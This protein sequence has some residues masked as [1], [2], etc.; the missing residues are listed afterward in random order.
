MKYAEAWE[1]LKDRVEAIIR[2]G[3]INWDYQDNQIETA[4]KIKSI[5]ECLEEEYE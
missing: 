3:Q 1:K 4:M 2:D 5:M